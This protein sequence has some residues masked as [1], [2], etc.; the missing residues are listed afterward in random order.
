M[1]NL[2][3][4]ATRAQAQYG[5]CSKNGLHEVHLKIGQTKKRNI[6]RQELFRGDGFKWCFGNTS[7]RIHDPARL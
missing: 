7:F 1:Q 5:V 4:Q 2:V 6:T 3:Y